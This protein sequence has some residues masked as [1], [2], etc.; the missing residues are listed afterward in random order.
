VLLTEFNPSNPSC[1]GGA[2]ENCSNVLSSNNMKESEWWIYML[3]LI[4]LFAGF[5]ILG[6]I[7]LVKKAKRFY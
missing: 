2:A 5:R 1:Q 7:I 4:A 6:A 3:L